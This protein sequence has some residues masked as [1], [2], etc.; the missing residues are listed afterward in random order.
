MIAGEDKKPRWKSPKSLLS[1]KFPTQELWLPDAGSSPICC[2]SQWYRKCH[3][4]DPLDRSL[5]GTVQPSD[6]PRDGDKETED[7]SGTVGRVTE[8]HCVVVWWL[9]K[10]L[11]IKSGQ[12]LD[13]SDQ[14]PD[15][16]VG[17]VTGRSGDP[18]N[19]VRWVIPRTTFWVMARFWVGLYKYPSHTLLKGLLATITSEDTLWEPRARRK[20]RRAT[21][22]RDLCDLLVFEGE[23]WASIV[24]LAFNELREECWSYYS[25]SLAWP[26]PARSRCWAIFV[27][28]CGGRHKFVHGVRHPWKRAA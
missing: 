4:L 18:E 26:W 14:S 22:K 28:G 7:R 12:C 16:P 13:S 20:K 25:W 15:N 17:M 23:Y 6:G 21:S 10:I 24:S 1:N 19:A 3:P 8:W 2:G 5:N 27:F 11:G 9:R